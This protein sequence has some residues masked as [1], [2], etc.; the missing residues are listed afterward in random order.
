MLGVFFV[1]IAALLLLDQ[2]TK[3]IV[4]NT[5][6]KVDT[7]ALIDGIFHLTYCENRGAAFGIMQ[8][9]VWFFVVVTV[10]VFVAVIWYMIK[11]KPKNKW[12]NFS[13]TLLMGGALGNFVDRI[14][15][16]YVVDFLDFRLI[17]FPIFNVADCFVVI[18]AILLACHIIFS[19][20]EKEKKQ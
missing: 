19:E 12:L 4:L 13:L 8:N 16:G 11:Y 3:R 15:R 5:L 17:N 2:L 20:Y 10:A 9:R 18:G 6:T 1:G 7:V 14:F